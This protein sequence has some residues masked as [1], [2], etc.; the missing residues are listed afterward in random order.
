ML[1][2]GRKILPFCLIASIATAV[3]F[4]PR[5]EK[6]AEEEKRVV[7]VWNVD[8]FEGGKGSRTA[9]LKRAATVLEKKDASVYYLVSSYTPEGAAAAYEEGIIPDALSF[10]VG[11]SLYTEVCLPLPR[12]F[13]GGE[14]GGV[15]LAYP[16]CRG[17]YFLFSLSD[18]FT[19]KGTTV[20]SEGG[21][22]LARVSA[23]LEG[24]SGEAH[25]S[26][27]AYVEFLSGK[28]RYL[29]GTQRDVCRLTSRGVS[30]Y[31]RALTE[32]NDLYQYFAVL[33]AETRRDCEALLDVLLS[34]EVQGALSEIGMFPV[35]G[36]EAKRT[37]SVF[38][39]GEALE[40]LKDTTADRDGGKNLVK[41]L[42]NI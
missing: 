14:A 11:L 21:A 38:T 26:L 34:E 12:A 9:F 22:N 20:I 35:A 5:Q 42:K 6:I 41:I 15:T 8:T 28:Y 27:S 18:D 13:A 10:G 31:S 3:V 16:W 1:R 29:L 33:S 24:I 2:T 39:D 4:F 30:F 40:K 37:V 36:E 32:F 19:Q 17:G 23:C 7:R 25:D